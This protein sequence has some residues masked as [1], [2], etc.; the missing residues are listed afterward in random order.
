[1]SPRPKLATRSRLGLCLVFETV[2]VTPPGATGRSIDRRRLPNCFTHV[3]HRGRLWQHLLSPTDNQQPLK[4]QNLYRIDT[5][6]AQSL[7]W[8][9][10]SLITVSFWTGYLTPRFIVPGGA[11]ALKLHTTMQ[12]FIYPQGYLC[13]Q[14][15]NI[16]QQ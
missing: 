1:M 4:Y 12:G 3:R 11:W 6:A 13:S 10:H 7:D 9:G 5:I 15:V 2:F 8:I 16:I 14:I